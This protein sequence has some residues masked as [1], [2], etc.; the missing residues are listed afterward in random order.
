V[1]V[2]LS[3]GSALAGDAIVM[4]PKLSA[5]LKQYVESDN[6]LK[7]KFE[8]PRMPGGGMELE[9][10]RLYGV[11][12]K[13]ESA[14]AGGA[15][16][17][18]KFERAM[19]Q[20]DSPMFEAL[21]D[22]DDPE[23]EEA[24]EQLGAALQAMLGI[25]FTLEFNGEMQATACS[26]MSAISEKVQEEAAGNAMLGQLVGELTDER[27]QKDWGDGLFYLYPNRE[28]RPGDTWKASLK[29]N[30]PRIG[31]VVSHAECKFDR[32]TRE[33]GHEVAIVTYQ[34]KTESD[35][36]EAGEEREEGD[37]PAPSVSGSF[38]GTATF[39]V[40]RGQ[41]V[42]REEKRD[43]TI[44]TQMP[45]REGEESPGQMKIQINGRH[46]LRVMSDADRAEQKAGAAREREVARKKAEEEKK[47]KKMERQAARKKAKPTEDEEDEEDDEDE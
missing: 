39:D 23:N 3:A 19:Q 4:K 37:P 17:E 13:V 29:N 20:V 36:A 47:R 34:G 16:I 41:F 28:V 32:V 9:V 11:M 43:V 5:G 40:R 35:T 44:T 7:Q 38:S 42:K 30:I 10:R 12:Q 24:A 27:A 22:T 2:G 25:P 1:V 21:F 45:G 46:T 33:D 14:S 18:M 26:G 31:K 6:Q 8:N 15:K